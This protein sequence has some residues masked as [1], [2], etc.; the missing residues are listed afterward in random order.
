ML[1]QDPSK[2]ITDPRLYT[3]CIYGEP[4]IGKTSWAAQVPGAYFIR[5]EE[6]TKG[7]S[8]YGEPCLSWERF[9]DLCVDLQ[10]GKE[11]EWKDQREIKNVIVDTVE[12]L[13]WLCGSWIARTKR[14]MIKGVPQ[15]YEDIRFVPY[16]QGYIEVNNEIIRV[17][18]KLVVLGF[19]LI[20]IS[21][22][23]ERTIK[24]RGEELQKVDP[25]LPPSA[26]TMIIGYCDAVGYFSMEE[27][28]KKE[29]V[30]VKRVEIGRYQYWQPS[31]L[32]MAKH[33]LTGFP[34]RLPLPIDKGYEVYR[35]AFEEATKQ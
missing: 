11:D 8:V 15:E 12:N 29:G 26:L 35:Q 20:L 27:E 2:I 18:N 17:F 21:H 31:F 33:R 24:W 23:K 16:G 3:T 4:G 22:E 1:Q 6:G 30:E 25:N 32:R 34:E 14:F 13:Y 19:G 28:I 7:I 10:K 9:L 5:T